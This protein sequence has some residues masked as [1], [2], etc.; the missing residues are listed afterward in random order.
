MLKTLG[1]C[2]LRLLSAPRFVVVQRQDENGKE[3][4]EEISLF[5]KHI[6]Y[7]YIYFYVIYIYITF[8]ILYYL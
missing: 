4:R 2:R 3:A 7:I 5:I 1:F 6:Y 8:I